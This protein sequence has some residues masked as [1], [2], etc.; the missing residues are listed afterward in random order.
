M[1]DVLRER[2]R[3]AVRLPE[4]ARP[5]LP[6]TVGY[7]LT[8]E[9]I[10][11]RVSPCAVTL[12]LATTMAARARERKRQARALA[13]VAGRRG[14]DGRTGLRAHRPPELRDQDARP[15]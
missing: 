15:R 10:R 2:A 6:E 8:D 9:V 5:A 3:H 12:G 13:K 11:G 7:I 1:Y 14:D 4:P